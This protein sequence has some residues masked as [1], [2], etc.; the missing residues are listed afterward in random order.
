M[1]E[2]AS[3]KSR[4]KTELQ[5]VSSGIIIPE[6]NLLVSPGIQYKGD[7]IMYAR[8]KA[9][10]LDGFVKI[11]LNNVDIENEMWIKYVSEDEEAQDVKIDFN[12]AQTESGE[13]LVAGLFYESA[14]NFVYG[15]FMKEKLSDTDMVFFKPSGLLRFNN[16]TGSFVIEDSAKANGNSFEGKFFSYN[17]ATGTIAFEG[18]MNFLEQNQNLSLEASG[19]GKG[20]LKGDN[21]EI[22]AFAKF[23][24]DMP[25][26]VFSIMAKDMQEVVE[27]MGLPPAEPDPDAILY[28]IAEFVGDRYTREYDTRMA[29]DYFPLPNLSSK[30][31]S[32][33]VFSKLNLSW[34]EKYNSWYSTGKVGLSHIQK[35]DINAASEGFIEIQ[36]TVDR[37]DIIHLFVQLSGDCWYYIQYGENRLITYSS[38]ANYNDAIASRSKVDKAGFGEY[39]FILGEKSDVTNYINRFRLDYMGIK[40]NYQ[41]DVRPVQTQETPVDLLFQQEVTPADTTQTEPDF[42]MPE[43]KPAV[44]KTEEEVEENEGF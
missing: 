1:Q 38:N 43:E 25:D 37:G 16:E 31:N 32:D 17:D 29:K 39:A 27:Y 2:I 18:P 42:W 11:V 21:L 13:P 12:L 30:L 36:K 20:T 28:K 5:T 4:N 7:L 8:Q 6:D 15:S 44:K 3:K 41:L 24:F 19:N 9:L 14:T 22:D 26:Q 35:N 34:S 10:K 23:E 40:E 33:M